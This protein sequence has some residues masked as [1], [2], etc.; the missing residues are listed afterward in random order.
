MAS[1][2]E[3]LTITTLGFVL[4]KYL[5]THQ[6]SFLTWGL[7]YHTVILLMA[8][9]DHIQFLPRGTGANV[10]IW[11]GPNYLRS[12]ISRPQTCYLWSEICGG[13]D[14]LGSDISN[15]SKNYLGSDISNIFHCPSHFLVSSL[16]SKLG[17]WLFGVFEKVVPDYL[18]VW[19]NCLTLAPPFQNSRSLPGKSYSHRV[20]T[21]LEAWKSQG[22]CLESQEICDRIQKV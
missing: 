8:W 3:R 13:R 1:L 7:W 12:E 19:E 21:N 20:A 6:N 15:M 14:Y 4:H 10:L 22:I 18:G 5:S 2:C 17:S 9:K 11:G 16:F